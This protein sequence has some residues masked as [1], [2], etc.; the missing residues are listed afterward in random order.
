MD[1]GSCLVIGAWDLEFK[2]MNHLP[3]NVR[4]FENAEAIFQAA[5]EWILHL[6]KSSPRFSIALSGGSTPKGLFQKMSGPDFKN[7]FPWQRMHFFWGDE[8]WV[9][10]EDSRNNFRMTREN[11]LDPARILRS[12]VHPIPTQLKSPEASAR[13]YEKNLRTFF[14]MKNI[15]PVFD[16]ILLGMGEDGHTASLFPDD[17]ALEEQNQWVVPA[18]VKSSEP[19]I[20]LTFPVLNAAKN[21]LFLITGENKRNVLRSILSRE[22]HAFRYPAARI[23]PSSGN[24]IWMLDQA[25]SGQS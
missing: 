20:T 22:D 2:V 13:A 24:L 4:V 12:N 16:L 18:R 15:F 9:P 5:A 8:R 21:I 7:Q 10:Q 23:Q 14:D 6:A 17:T 3:S 25:A 11:L 1:F 19:R